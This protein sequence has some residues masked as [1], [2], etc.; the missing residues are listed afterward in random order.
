MHC[1]EITYTAMTNR[2]R[3]T[4]TFAYQPVDHPPL[5][6]HEDMCFKN[7]PL[8]S[9]AMFREF[10]TPYYRR[11]VGA[12][13]DR[14]QT[15]FV[16]DSAGDIRQLIPLWLE[17]GVNIMSPIEIAAGLDVCE[18]RSE[19]GRD[20]MM[21]GGSI[22][23]RSSPA[24]LRS[25]SSCSLRNPSSPKAATSPASIMAYHPMYPGRTIATT[26]SS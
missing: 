8:I 16:Q 5:G 22:S 14:G 26:S 18:L 7:G 25:A 20:L 21:M 15:L 12:A 17:V 6:G 11:T 9:P 2:D 13:R 19:Y 24:K 3:F 10:L 1:L 4:R 23:A